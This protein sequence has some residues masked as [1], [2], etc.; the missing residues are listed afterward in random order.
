MNRVISIEICLYPCCRYDDVIYCCALGPDV[1]LLPAGDLTEIGE[2]GINL[3]GGQ[4]Q[5][6]NVARAMYSHAQILLLVGYSLP[7]IPS[8]KEYLK[9]T[10][11]YP[12][13]LLDGDNFQVS[14]H[15]YASLKPLNWIYCMNL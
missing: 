1:D 6:V 9:G 2:R 5:R 10:L 15:P 13:D 12:G 4:K 11:R 7:C 8:G 14:F 3:S